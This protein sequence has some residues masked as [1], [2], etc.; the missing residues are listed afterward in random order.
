[1]SKNLFNDTTGRYTFLSWNTKADGSGRSFT[2]EQVVQYLATDKSI[3]LYAQWNDAFKKYSH[4]SN[5]DNDGTA[6]GTYATNLATTDTVKMD[7][8][9]KLKVEVWV[10][11]ESTSYDWLELRDINGTTLTKDANGTTIGSSGKLGR[12]YS[13]TKP[14]NSQVFYIT[15]D[16]VQFYFKSDSSGN[17]YGYYAIISQAE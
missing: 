4:T 10:S 8:A 16:T 12:G 6:S 11:T 3:T 2:D 7:G 14:S 9:K 5:I 1:M 17:Y 15:G 13:T